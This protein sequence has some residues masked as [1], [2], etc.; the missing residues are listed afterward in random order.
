M[1]D[2][3]L[4]DCSRWRE[5]TGSRSVVIRRP[6]AVFIHLAHHYPDV[7]LPTSIS[8]TSNP[9][10]SFQATCSDLCIDNILSQGLVYVKMAQ[11]RA[12][13]RVPLDIVYM[14]IAETDDVATLDSWCEAS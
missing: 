11:S 14:I 8:S 10:R 4:S 3:C 12:R 9:F 2:D 7:L 6:H 1:I 13:S 5:V